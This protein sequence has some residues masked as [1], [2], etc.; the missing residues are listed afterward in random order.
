MGRFQYVNGTR[1]MPL[2][3]SQTCR[4]HSGGGEFCMKVVILPC[5]GHY[6]RLVLAVID[7]QACFVNSGA[8]FI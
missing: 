4:I 1:G 8:L 5:P 2:N 7:E 6:L 3:M